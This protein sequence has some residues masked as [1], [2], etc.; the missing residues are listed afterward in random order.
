M[1]K[2]FL[3][4]GRYTQN[5]KVQIKEKARDSPPTFSNHAGA[6][7]QEGF[8][9]VISRICFM[10]KT[11]D[12]SDVHPKLQRYKGIPSPQIS[13]NLPF[14][15]HP[16]CEDGFKETDICRLLRRDRTDK[17]LSD[18]IFMSL[19]LCYALRRIAKQQDRPLWVVREGTTSYTTG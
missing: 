2:I 17:I 5:L 16:Y 18:M 6:T 14:L 13:T 11:S 10:Y 19:F 12:S 4:N 3:L 8:Q 1:F 7:I 15:P 9:C